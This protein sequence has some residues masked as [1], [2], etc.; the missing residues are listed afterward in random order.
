MQICKNYLK[1]EKQE[2]FC[3]EKQYILYLDLDK[4]PL[5][6]IF[7]NQIVTLN[8]NGKKDLLLDHLQTNRPTNIFL[9]MLTI[10]HKLR[11]FKFYTSVPIGSG[12]ISFGIQSPMFSSSTLVELHMTVYRFDECLFLLDGRLNQLRILFVTTFHIL[13]L[14]R[15]IINRANYLARYSIIKIDKFRNRCKF[16]YH[17]DHIIVLF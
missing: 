17:D 3:Q 16:L 2:G 14:Q 9:N 11:H 6:D 8:I 5:I 15:T 1:K 10:C 12:F 7:Q 4:S 13:P